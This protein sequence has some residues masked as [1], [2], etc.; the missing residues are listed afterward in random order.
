M[1]PGYRR[2]CCSLPIQCY[3]AGAF[4]EGRFD[5]P[6]NC[7]DASGRVAYTGSFGHVLNTE[8]SFFGVS[9]VT[10][11]PD[12]RYRYLI[13]G[14]TLH[15]IQSLDATRSREPLAYYTATGP[16]GE[17]FRAAQ[18][19][20]PHGDW[21]IVGLGAGAMACYL[22]PGQTLTYYEIDPLVVRLAKDPRYFTFMEHCAPQ[23]RIVLG[24]ARLKLHH[25]PD[26]HYGLIVLDAFSGDS[27]PMHLLTREALAMYQRKLAP[28][29][30]LHC[31]FPATI[32]G[33]GQRWATWQRTRTWFAYSKTI[34]MF[35]RE[36]WMR[37][38][39]LLY[40]W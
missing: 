37:G 13:H 12:G 25:A 10:N 24:D 2:S 6:G 30:L 40:G 4:A 36:K 23:A 28:G 34:P 22:Q 33:F 21:A 18:A 19:K 31:I 38:K 8:R 1:K 3:G 17:I 11:S 14:G 7:G 29:G 9:R 20:A 15:G 27:I 16:A 5:L 32:F 39:P 35:L 26:A